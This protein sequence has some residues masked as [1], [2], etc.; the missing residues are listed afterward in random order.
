MRVRI[1]C[2]DEEDHLPAIGQT[3]SD[4][5]NAVVRGK[6]N[7]PEHSPIQSLLWG[8]G[9][10]EWEQVRRSLPFSPYYGG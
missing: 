6:V 3:G 2:G 5:S 1:V 10:I 7:P 4:V 9:K 8:L